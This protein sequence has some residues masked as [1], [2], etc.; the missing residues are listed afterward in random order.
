[1]CLSTFGTCGGQ[2]RVSD[3]LGWLSVSTEHQAWSLL[4]EPQVPSATEPS[5]QPLVSFSETGF[6]SV[7]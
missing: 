6:L 3:P 4:E 1:M 5:L 7:I 2:K